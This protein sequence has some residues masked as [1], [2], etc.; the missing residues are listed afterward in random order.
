MWRRGQLS[1][2]LVFVAVSGG[3][4]SLLIEAGDFTNGAGADAGTPNG[5]EDDAETA[6]QDA[7]PVLND[8]SFPCPGDAGAPGVYIDGYCIDATEVTRA[9]YAIFLAATGNDPSGQPEYC[10]WNTTYEPDGWSPDDVDALP[11]TRL[12][13]CDARAY[14]AWA[15][16]RLCGTIGG[17]SSSFASPN[18]P[19]DQWYR[20]CSG[21]DQR[22]YAYGAMYVANW[23]NI[24]EA[25]SASSPVKSFPDCVGSQPGLF[26]MIGNVS[27]WIDGCDR[28]TGP[29][30]LCLLHES[31][32]RSGRSSSCTSTKREARSSKNTSRGFRCCAP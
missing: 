28:W 30:D 3:A 5:G 23:C 1:I 11:V 31:S 13:W 17:G 21:N 4:C 2:T 29:D 16:K 12:D 20:A 27:E 15:G 32:Y 8:A 25:S 26:D 7:S 6:T 19:S 24:D 9:E 22:A 18:V 10:A 14:C